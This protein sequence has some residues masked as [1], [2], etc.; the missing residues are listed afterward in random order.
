MKESQ[1]KKREEVIHQRWTILITMLSFLFIAFTGCDYARMKEQEALQTY[2]TQIPE[3]PER[4]IPVTGGLQSLRGVDPETLRNP[5]SFSQNSIHLGRLT[6]RYY[7]FVCH[8]PKGDGNGTVGQSFAPL[9]TDLR[10]SY[11]QAQSDGKLFYT[12]TFGLKRHPPLGFMIAEKDRWAIVHYV[13]SLSKKN[14][15][16]RPK[17]A[18]RSPRS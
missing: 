14:E 7:C 16:L 10:S 4:T 2:R 6:Y 15:F 11:V 13:R 17:S 9:P 12:I 3:M 5:L 1:K 8:G 18:S